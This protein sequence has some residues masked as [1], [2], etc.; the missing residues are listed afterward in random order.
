MRMIYFISD[1]HFSDTGI[2][3]TVGRPFVTPEEMDRHIT[4]RVAQKTRDA[5]A[6]YILGDVFGGVRPADQFGTLCRLMREMGADERPFHLMRGNHDEL[7]D[8]EYRSAGFASVRSRWAELEAG[9]RRYV[10]AH[11]P[12]MIQVPGTF[13][14][15]GHVHTLYEEVWNERRGTLDVNVGVEVRGYEPLSLSEIDEIGRRYPIGA[16]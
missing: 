7:T 4:S 5:E 2:M 9:S 1:L 11:D 8:E 12:S 15:T 6:V 3:K 14:I 10:I 16:R 13:A